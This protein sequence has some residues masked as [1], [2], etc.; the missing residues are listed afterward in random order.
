M[1]IHFLLQRRKTPS[2]IVIAV[3]RILRARGYQ[4]SS[5]IAEDTLLRVDEGEPSE[6]L[7]LLKSYSEL[8]LS[9][10]GVL[11][12]SGALL[13]N[14]FAGCYAARNKLLAAQ[15]LSQGY[16]PAPRSWTTADFGQ[17]RQLVR[18]C[19]LIVKSY[20]GWRGEG[21]HVLHNERDLARLPAFTAPVIVQEYLRGDGEDLRLYVA[22]E[23]VFGVKKAFS[24]TSY[25]KPGR[26]VEVTPMVRD[27]ALCCGRLFGLGIY[28]VD[29]IETADGPKVVDVNYFPGFKGVA[30]AAE[31]VADYIESLAHGDTLPAQPAMQLA[32]GMLR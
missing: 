6:G 22:G 8:G 1:R 31:V 14:S 19:P 4:I 28:G 23:R 20:M 24:P 29:L 27:I 21:V 18:E 32:G 9:M 11:E 26:Q 13:V 30:G 25:S 17:L 12:A 16:I 7:Y 2:H 5:V 10:A 15:V 3:S